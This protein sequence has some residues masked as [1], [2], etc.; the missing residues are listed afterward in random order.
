MNTHKVLAV[1]Y[2]TPVPGYKNNVVNVVRLWSAKA[3]ASFHLKF[4][5]DGD[6]LKAVCDRNSAE[7]I[8]RVLY[9][10]DNMFEGKTLRLKQE[11]F[12]VSASL[13]DSIRRYKSLQMGM[14]TVTKDAFEEFPNKIAFQL[15]DTHP[16]LAIPELMR[17]LI[18]QEGL[19]WEQAW[20]IVFRTCAYTNH[21]ILPE[22]LERWPVSLMEELLPRILDIIYYINHLFLIEVRQMFP[23]DDNRMRRMSIVE[24]G[25]QRRINMAHLA[26]VGS[27]A[28]NGVAQI[29]SDILKRT[30]FRDFY[31][32]FPGRFQNK[33]NGITPRRWLMLCNPDLTTLITSKLGESWVKHLSELKQLV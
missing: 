31:E 17:I 6:Y 33:T 12:L 23:G 9:P 5:N 21:T 28:I 16:A 1:P 29:H 2:D 15:N 13:Q 19:P 3:E 25:D 8:S 20:N 14:F 11:Y 7:N 26:I 27:H 10:N 30:T 24:E 22:A 18:D 4:F 32:M